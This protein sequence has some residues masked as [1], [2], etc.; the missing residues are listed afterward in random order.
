[1]IKNI[2][3]FVKIR[4]ICILYVWTELLVYSS[5]MNLLHLPFSYFHK[6]L[7]LNGPYLF[8]QVAAEAIKTFMSSIHSI[9]VQ[10][11]EERQLKKKS[12]NMESKFQTQLEKHSENAMQNSAQPPN[13]NQYSV[14]KN[15]MKLD[16]FRK[17]VEEEKARYL[18]SVKTSRTM[19]LNNLQTGLP[20]VFHA[21][22]GFSGVCV[23]AFEGISRCSE[24]AVS[25][26]GAISPAICV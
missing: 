4:N 19:T 6:L 10:Q 12:D 7:C 21:L 15:E 17:Q 20:K 16:A 5:D 8:K 9:V 2:S 25:H 3:F 1:M 11:S 23:Q 14:S 22:M 24:V 13:K 18:I 26:S